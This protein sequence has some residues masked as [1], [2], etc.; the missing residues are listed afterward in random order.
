VRAALQAGKTKSDAIA[1]GRAALSES[2]TL[3]YLDV[4]DGTSFAPVERLDA[5]AFVI[6]AARFGKTRLIDNLWIAASRPSTGS[7]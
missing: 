4:V 5:P 1:A 7:G 2:A 6:G 3:E